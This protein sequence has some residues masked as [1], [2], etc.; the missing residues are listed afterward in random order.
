MIYDVSK[1]IS[2]SDI[3]KLLFYMN[4]VLKCDELMMLL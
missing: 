4:V 1:Y 2:F 3:S